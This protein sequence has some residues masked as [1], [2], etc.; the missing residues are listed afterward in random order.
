M[1]YEQILQCSLVVLFVEAMPLPQARRGRWGHA[2]AEASAEPTCKPWGQVTHSFFI[3]PLC[4]SKF[5]A[6]VLVT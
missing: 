5:Y 2:M 1:Y 6:L 4:F 3:A